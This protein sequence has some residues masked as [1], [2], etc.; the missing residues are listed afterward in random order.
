MQTNSFFA[1]HCRQSSMKV[2]SSKISIKCWTVIPLP[3]TLNSILC[4]SFFGENFF[5]NKHMFYFPAK[6]NTQKVSFF[7]CFPEICMFLVRSC[8]SSSAIQ[9]LSFAFFL[10][11]KRNVFYHAN[12]F[13]FKFVFKYTFLMFISFINS[14]YNTQILLWF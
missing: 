12:M 5:S 7:V 9:K 10:F 1:L 14:L 4:F 3:L 2:F 11:L 8:L 13:F 6:V